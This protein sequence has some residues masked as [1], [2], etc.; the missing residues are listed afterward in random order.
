MATENI[1][2]KDALEFKKNKYYTSAFKYTDVVNSQLPNSNI[3]K[4]NIPLN[5]DNFPVL[6]KSHHFFNSKKTKLKP[7]IT[8]NKNRDVLP[9]EPFY[10]PPNGSYLNNTSNQR[11]SI[12]NNSNDFSWVH[13]LSQKLSETLINSPS[14]SSPFSSSSLQ[15]LIESSLISLLAIP[16]FKHLS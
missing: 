6:N 7:H 15:S 4:P 12:D 2:Y 13:A 16:N 9:V 3:L 14:L 10:S 5:E 1:S 11:N 8:S